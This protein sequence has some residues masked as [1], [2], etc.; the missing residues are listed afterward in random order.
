LMDLLLNDR[1]AGAEVVFDPQGIREIRFCIVRKR[2]SSLDTEL[3][4]TLRSV[5]ELI[6]LAGKLPLSLVITG[7]VVLQKKISYTEGTQVLQKVLPNAAPEDFHAQSYP[8]GEGAAYVAVARK[9]HVND[10]LGEEFTQKVFLWD[11]F[12]G[13]YIVQVLAP[14]IPSG[15][16]H[17]SDFSARF[18]E[19]QLEE[20][21]AAEGGHPFIRLGEK[22]IPSDQA[23]SFSAALSYFTGKAPYTAPL[24]QISGE[25]EK[26]RQKKL[27]EAGGRAALVFFLGILLLNYFVFD[28]YW[29]KKSDLEKRS[30][31]NRG[32][33]AKY[34]QL[35]QEMEEKKK[36]FSMSGFSAESRLSFYADRLAAGLPDNIRLNKLNLYPALP[37]ESSDSIMRFSNREI[38]VN[39]TCLKSIDLNNWIKSL[40]QNKWIKEVS[41]L[42]YRHEPDQPR[43]SFEISLKTL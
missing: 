13:P 14:L 40:R 26:F 43:G 30:S 2:K 42:H 38:L 18:G 27:F 25:K 34:N 15:Q 23:L 7:K 22:S 16:I 19:D 28:H 5:D 21:S 8:I 1:A 29:R 17:A 4:R 9:L 20:V 31:L 3:F 37:R 11:C 32:L 36:L 10:V 6:S 39:G 35:S 24:P 33:M 12:L 41:I